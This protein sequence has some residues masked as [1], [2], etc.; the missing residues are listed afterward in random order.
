MDGWM[1]GWMGMVGGGSVWQ[2]VETQNRTEQ[3]VWFG[4]LLPLHST[5]AAAA[6][7]GFVLCVFEMARRSVAGRRGGSI[8][9]TL[10]L[11]FPAPWTGM[12]N[13]TSL[14]IHRA[15]DNCDLLCVEKA[16]GGREGEGGCVRHSTDGSMRNTGEQ[17]DAAGWGGRGRR[18]A[19]GCPAGLG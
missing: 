4:L 17:N 5:A 12:G 19:C 9:D 16:D 8:D 15:A 1:D 13:A 7:E 18:R 14:P 2:G 11:V 10:H 6:T 3:E